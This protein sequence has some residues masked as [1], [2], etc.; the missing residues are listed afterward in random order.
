MPGQILTLI[1]ADGAGKSS[2][3]R[4]IGA[5]VGTRSIGMYMG[6]NPHA[7]THG[8]PTIWVWNRLKR[9]LGKDVHTGG[10]PEP[11]MVRP[12]SSR[13]GRLLSHLK[14]LAV[15]GLRVSDDAYRLL[16]A[17]TYARLG[18]LVILDRHPYLDYRAHRVENTAGWRRWGDRI[19]GFL[20]EHV[21][22]RPINLVLLDAP[23]EVLHGRKPEGSLAAVRARRQEYLSVI[24]TVPDVVVLDVSKSEDEVMAD[25]LTFMRDRSL[26]GAPLHPS[27]NVAT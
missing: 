2:I 24:G 16:L 23:A 22:P 12:P 14:S 21:Y 10:P 1:G 11:G 6:A 27:S 13:R 26:I 15:L 5:R 8:L 18:Y 20:L 9:L 3:A 4:R 7:R 19:H 17:A 25:V